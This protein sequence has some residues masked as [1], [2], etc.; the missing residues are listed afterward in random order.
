MVSN[1]SCKKI[2]KNGLKDRIRIYCE[3][4]GS[5]IGRDDKKSE[6]EEVYKKQPNMK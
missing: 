6:P 2:K 3:I 5:Q 4:A 1:L